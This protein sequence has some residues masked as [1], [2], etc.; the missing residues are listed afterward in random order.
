MVKLRNQLGAMRGLLP[1][2]PLAA[3]SSVCFSLAVLAAPFAVYLPVKLFGAAC[4][5]FALR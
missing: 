2:A 1:H 4:Y 3:L 5:A